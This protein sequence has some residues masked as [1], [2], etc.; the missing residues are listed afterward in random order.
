MNYQ[1][2]I[3][4]RISQEIIRVV[5]EQAIF[6]I[7]C[8]QGMEDRHEGIHEARKSLKKVRAVLR[9]SRTALLPE[10]FLQANRTARD[11][12][13]ELSG[14]RDA[15]ALIEALDKLREFHPEWM[16]AESF[17]EVRALLETRRDLLF[18]E[19][20]EEANI[21][22]SVI[23]HLKAF[24]TWAA[25]W[26]PTQRSFQQAFQPGLETIYAQGIE[27]FHLAFAQP[28]AHH[29]HEW[30]KRVKDLWYHVLLLEACWPAVMIPFGDTLHSL[31]DVLGDEHD[32]NVFHELL[33]QGNL[34][35]TTAEVTQPLLHLFEQQV[36][37]LRATAFELGQKM[38]ADTPHTFGNHFA[39][40]WREARRKGSGD[41]S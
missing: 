25:T 2:V 30:R 13:R 11:L 21:D 28:S 20:I 18:R 16:D 35:L 5:S 8:L 3:Q 27:A 34:S 6:A 10:T 19:M 9:L 15:S 14:L 41:P 31:S 33:S 37:V 24:R 39:H 22:Q 1:F 7:E 29:F 32:L 40:C 17:F 23:E 4:A 36:E 38:Y 26:K 12:G